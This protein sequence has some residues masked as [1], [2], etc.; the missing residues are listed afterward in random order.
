M[1]TDMM[2]EREQ[3]HPRFFFKSPFKSFPISL[4]LSYGSTAKQNWGL[5]GLR[6]VSGWHTYLHMIRKRRNCMVTIDG[7]KL[8]GGMQPADLPQNVFFMYVLLKKPARPWPKPRWTGSRPGGEVVSTPEW[9]TR[10]KCKKG[11]SC[12]CW[13]FYFFCLGGAPTL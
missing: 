2:M 5:E 8:P 3:M 6:R 4:S 1:H 9:S 13:P 7:E 10:Q 11:W 12:V